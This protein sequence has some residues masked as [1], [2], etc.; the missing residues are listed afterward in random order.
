MVWP[1]RYATADRTRDT[2]M[3]LTPDLDALRFEL[4]A[5]CFDS[6]AHQFAHFAK[7]GHTKGIADEDAA[8]FGIA[9][10]VI[11][12]VGEEYRRCAIKIR[13]TE[14]ILA[15][16]FLH[17]PAVP[18]D[19]SAFEASISRP[20]PPELP[21]QPGCIGSALLDVARERLAEARD[22]LDHGDSQI[23]RAATQAAALL[24][25]WCGG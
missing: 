7:F 16:P 1:A 22:T 2:D 11:D 5:A 25:T 19:P 13:A 24:H 15:A 20:L 18:S 14:E 23:L 8:Q 4:A 17:Q 21:D 10:D 3:S 9:G 12:W 6:V